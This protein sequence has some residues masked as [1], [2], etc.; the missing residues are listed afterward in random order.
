MLEENRSELVALCV[1]EAGKT[2][3]DAHAEVREAV[4]FCRYY[5]QSAV[6]L[7]AQPLSLTG[8]TGALLI[9]SG[10]NWYFPSASMS[11][12]GMNPFPRSTTTWMVS[13]ISP[14]GIHWP[15]R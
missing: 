5:A 4:D 7:F 8:A 10:T 6:E 11:P 14:K 1:Y 2:I 9:P 13:I 15:L 12:R 3:Q